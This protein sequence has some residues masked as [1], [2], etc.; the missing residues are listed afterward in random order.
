MHDKGHY[1]YLL[2]PV[3]DSHH[4][5]QRP[6]EEHKVEV[7]IAV[8]GALNLIIN[9]TPL[10]YLILFLCSVWGKQSQALNEN[11]QQ[12]AFVVIIQI[13]NDINL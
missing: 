12:V 8:H 4:D 5:I 10:L 3:G 6:K 13:T 11:G 1:S 9:A 7:G 2:K